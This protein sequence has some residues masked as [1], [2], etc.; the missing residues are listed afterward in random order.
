VKPVLDQLISCERFGV[1]VLTGESRVGAPPDCRGIHLTD[2]LDPTPWLQGGELIITTGLLLRSEDDQ[3]DFVE[4]VAARGCVALGY[5]AHDGAPVPRVMVETAERVGLP[6]FELPFQ[7]P[8]IDVTMFV[9]KIVL[10]RHY[11][12]LRNAVLL[13]RRILAAITQAA[14]LPVILQVAGSELPDYGLALVDYFGQVLAHHDPHGRLDGLDFSQ[15]SLRGESTQVRGE[16][17]DGDDT[18]RVISSWGLRVCSET[19]GFLVAVGTRPV[20]EREEL[21]LEQVVAGATMTLARELSIRQVRR[22]LVSELVEGAATNQVSQQVLLERMRKVAI[23][24]AS[25]FRL[26]CVPVRPGQEPG[27]V[28]RLVEDQL[29][30]QRPAV[31]FFDGAVY[32]IVA[33]GHDVAAGDVHAA[34]RRRGWPALIG[35]S[36]VHSGPDGLAVAHRESSAAARR[37]PFREGVHD[38]EDLDVVS[39]LGGHTGEMAGLIVDRVLGPLIEHDLSDGSRLV[40]SL[41]AFLRHGFKPGPAAAELFIHRHTLAYRLDRIAA[42]TGRDPRNGAHLLEFTLALELHLRVSSAE[43]DG[44]PEGGTLRARPIGA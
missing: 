44:V 22:T 16:R 15:P 41:A 28:C 37:A 3:R 17:P 10:D 14:G 9:T 4:R 36:R 26:L 1:R 11:A 32:A 39:L 25:S 31:G 43:P 20:D 42:I 33:A 7:V 12:A 13:H 40:E 23:D 21:L 35:R 8:L 6:V 29:I 18:G 2:M 30:Q 24:A 38:V 19:E 5:S 34:L 27:D